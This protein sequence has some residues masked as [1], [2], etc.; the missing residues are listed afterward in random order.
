MN[1]KFSEFECRESSKSD[2]LVDVENESVREINARI[3]LLRRKATELRQ[4]TSLLYTAADILADEVRRRAEL[5]E[6][7]K[8]T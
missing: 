7:Q 1:V 4:Q 2:L 6:T 5:M 8:T 3:Q